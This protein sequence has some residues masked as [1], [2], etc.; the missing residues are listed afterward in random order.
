MAEEGRALLGTKAVAKCADLSKARWPRTVAS[1]DP[2]MVMVCKDGVYVT[3]RVFF[4]EEWGYFVPRDPGRFHPKAG[5]DPAFTPLG[6]GVF[7]Y[8]VAG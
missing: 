6:S 1:L 5:S 8:R 7:W 4:A 3:L 2:E